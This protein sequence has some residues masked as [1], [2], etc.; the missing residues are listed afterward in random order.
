MIFKIFVVLLILL[1]IHL[2]AG[3][4]EIIPTELPY[5]VGDTLPDTIFLDENPIYW[6]PTVYS[7]TFVRFYHVTIDGIKYSYN[8]TDHY[9][10]G[11]KGDSIREINAIK[12][13]DTAFVTPEGLRVG[14]PFTDVLPFTKGEIIQMYSAHMVYA[15][16]PSGWDA[17]YFLEET[18]DIEGDLIGKNDTIPISDRQ[19]DFFFKSL[20]SF[21]FTKEDEYKIK[22]EGYDINRDD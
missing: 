1:S 14:Q 22:I 17:G 2:M 9:A 5:N 20:A 11:I 19:I 6:L 18:K 15:K 13:I 3:E 7:S 16:L 4:R 10:R 8:L 12:V 21:W